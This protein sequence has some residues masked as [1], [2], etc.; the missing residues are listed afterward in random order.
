MK[1][2]Y[3]LLF[4]FLFLI[5]EGV[6]IKFLP[7]SIV[8]SEQMMVPHWILLILIFVAVFFDK[9]HTYHA[10]LYAIIFGFLVDIVYTGILGV[11]MFS[12]GIVVYIIHSLK[13]FLHGNFFV[14][15]LFSI[16]GLI[17]SDLLITF[18]YDLVGIIKVSWEHYWLDRLVPTVILNLVFFIILYPILVK[19]L[20][21]WGS[22][23]N[24][25]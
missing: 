21:A 16:L 13:K 24:W 6:A 3:I 8:L 4:L 23:A 20:I 10:I 18:I 11:Y 22:E 1:R 7:S 19:R 15:L 12:Y 14:M 5:L 17:L 25:D 9:G 2:V